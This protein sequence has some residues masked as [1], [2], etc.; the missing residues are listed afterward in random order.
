MALSLPDIWLEPSPLLPPLHEVAVVAG[1]S[2]LGGIALAL[3]RER[4]LSLWP[5]IVAQTLG[6]VGCA[7]F[8]V[9]LAA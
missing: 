4:S 6:G 1:V 7:A 2:A 8:W 3:M 9:W 5:G